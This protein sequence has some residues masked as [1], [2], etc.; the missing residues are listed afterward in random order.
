MYFSPPLTLFGGL[1]AFMGWRAAR[2]ERGLHGAERG[3]DVD[4]SLMAQASSVPLLVMQCRAVG[5]PAPEA[6][7]RFHPTRKW[8]ADLLW[9]E[10]RKLIVEVEGGVYV[11][12]RH[13]RGVGLE[14][15]AEKY[16]HALLAGFP[17]LRVTPRQ[18]QQGHAVNWIEGYLRSREDVIASSEGGGR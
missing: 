4:G 1:L 13:S 15:D 9:R 2:R 8:R 5:L 3:R 12:G 6:E 16:A 18:V 14:A 10:P 7:V 17:V 11:Q